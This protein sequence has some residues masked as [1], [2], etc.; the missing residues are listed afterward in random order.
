MSWRNH[1]WPFDGNAK[2][3]LS[4]GERDRNRDQDIFGLI[5][6]APSLL[7]AFQSVMAFSFCS[8]KRNFLFSRG[9][10]KRKK[11][12]LFYSEVTIYG[13]IYSAVLTLTTEESLSNNVTSEITIR[14]SF[15]LT[16]RVW[17]EMARCEACFIDITEIE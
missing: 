14:S 3:N 8:R 4:V 16:R 15:N 17:E 9:C 11:F 1:Y 13:T 6:A 12:S 7:F 2:P 10:L 5:S